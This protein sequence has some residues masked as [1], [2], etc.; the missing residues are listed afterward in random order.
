MTV[1]PEKTFS[2]SNTPAA[3]PSSPTSPRKGSNTLGLE[4]AVHILHSNP[5]TEPSD[6]GSSASID[7]TG[8]PNSSAIGRRNDRRMDTKRYYTAGAIEDIKVTSW[9]F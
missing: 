7:Q 3:T 1:F 9:F 4:N 5:E 8:T 6:L 2:N